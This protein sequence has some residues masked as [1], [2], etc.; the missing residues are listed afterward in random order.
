MGLCSANPSPLPLPSPPLTLPEILEKAREV[1]CSSICAFCSRMKRGRLYTCA[2]REGYNVLAMGQ[3][4]DDLAES[5]LMAAFHNGFL[6]TMKAH[7]TIQSVGG[8][9]EGRDRGGAGEGHLSEGQL[10]FC[11]PGM[12]TLE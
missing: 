6:R 2:R 10:F 12:V 9:E 11:P 4:L 5:F 8:T 3:H 1:G 7:Y